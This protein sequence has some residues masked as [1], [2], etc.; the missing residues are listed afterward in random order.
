M[1][2]IDA[3]RLNKEIKSKFGYSS[4]T[5]FCR[6]MQDLSQ[7]EVFKHIMILIEEAPTIENRQLGKWIKNDYQPYD[8][9]TAFKCSICGKEIFAPN[10]IAA[11]VSEHDKY[12]YNCGTRMEGEECL[13]K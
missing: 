11:K 6:N 7:V 9:E 12:C 3:D 4:A 2:L 5:A 1:R 10:H 13:M 8:Y